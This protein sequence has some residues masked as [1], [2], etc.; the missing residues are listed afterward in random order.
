MSEIPPY[1]DEIDLIALIETLWANKLAIIASTMLS[2]IG[3]GSFLVFQTPHY[4]SR[5]ALSV[6][7]TPADKDASAVI[8][9]FV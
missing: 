6:H 9:T 4:E 1:D 2:L 7:L 8:S 5:L 3:A